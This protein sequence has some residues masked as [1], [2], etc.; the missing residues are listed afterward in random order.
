MEM[1]KQA[2]GAFCWFDL[3]TTNAVRTKEF[4]TKLL[5]WHYLPFKPDYEMICTKDEFSFPIGGLLHVNEP[6][7]TNRP[8][9]L[10]YFKVAELDPKVELLKALGAELIG[11]RVE[12]P[13]DNGCFHH[14]KDDSG[15]VVALWAIR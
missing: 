5:D 15:N 6:V 14:F 2:N 9:P 11:E 3:T 4:Y 13:G 10:V 8:G 12:I 7:N 1:L